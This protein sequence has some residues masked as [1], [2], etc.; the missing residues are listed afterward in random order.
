[1]KVHMPKPGSMKCLTLNA[2]TNNFRQYL[3]MK[4]ASWDIEGLSVHLT[5]NTFGPCASFFVKTNVRGKENKV[6]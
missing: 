4:I 6:R 1:M 3:I 5:K 2:P